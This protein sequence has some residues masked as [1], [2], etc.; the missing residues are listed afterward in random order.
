MST[1]TP[2]PR[3]DLTRKKC[4]SCGNPLWKDLS[5]GTEEC[6]CPYC[7]IRRV[8]FTIPVIQD[9]QSGSSQHNKKLKDGKYEMSRV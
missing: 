9:E 6:I 4:H 3:Y 8:K 7:L 1:N 5:K 2:P